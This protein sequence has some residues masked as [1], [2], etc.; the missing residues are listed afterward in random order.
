MPAK[1]KVTNAT[2]G[3]APSSVHGVDGRSQ[4]TFDT[5]P[6]GL[7]SDHIAVINYTRKPEVLSLYPVDAV[8]ATNGTISFPAQTAKRQQAGAWLAIGTPKASGQITVKP[9]STDI[10]PIQLKVPMNAPPGDHIGGILVSLNGLVNGKFGKGS[11][12][13]LKFA[14]RL[15]IKVLIHVSGPTH[16]NLSIQHLKSSYSGPIDPFAKGKVKITYQVHNGGNIV[17]GGP[18]TVTVHGLFGEK[19]VAKSVADVPP[20]L[21]DATYPVTVTVPAVYPEALMSVQ[22]SIDETG[23]QG[24]LTPGLHSVTSSVHS[25]AI[26]WILLI[27]LLLLILGLARGYRR[28]RRKSRPAQPEGRHRA[29]P[30]PQGVTQ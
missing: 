1:P 26:P 14:Q 21:P 28:R 23:L 17:L 27:V 5:T 20:L 13:K 22:V 19:V 4:F 6:G 7:G 16:P 25:L 10:L 8:S 30:E 3:A 11:V 24:D 2:F 15:A 29:K 9:R 12:Q 18:Q